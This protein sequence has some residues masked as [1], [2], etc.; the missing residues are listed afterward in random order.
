LKEKLLPR[1]L[2]GTYEFS[3]NLFDQNYR[4][5]F[6]KDSKTVTLIKKGHQ[7][8][9]EE[10]KGNKMQGFSKNFMLRER[11]QDVGNFNR[12]MLIKVKIHTLSNDFRRNL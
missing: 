7:H 4:L 5:M 11:H 2:V 1:G 9:S 8:H 10:A 3:T 12:F 6:V